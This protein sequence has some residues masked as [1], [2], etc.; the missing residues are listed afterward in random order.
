M[1]E[2]Q[3]VGGP[4]SRIDRNL[5][6]IIAVVVVALALAILK[7]WGEIAAPIAVASPPPTPTPSPAPTPVPARDVYDLASYGILEPPAIWE[8]WS[9]GTLASFS[10][11]LRIDLAPAPALPA[12]PTPSGAIESDDPT[13]PSATPASRPS[14]STF[15]GVPSQWP[16]VRIPTGSHLELIAINRPLDRTIE[17]V[18]LTQ[19][20]DAGTTVT[21]PTVEAR[22]PWPSHVTVVGLGQ[23]GSDGMR[24]W[25]AGRYEMTLRIGPEGVERTLE[26]VVD[27]LPDEL[28]PSAAPSVAPGG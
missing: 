24:Q 16:P 3:R 26:I 5:G 10:F 19:E 8:V 4:P 21:L 27:T 1:T 14:P 18:S 25:P 15:V 13:R 23:D 6:R 28:V 7:P 9:A 11:A 20:A 22:S 2:L 17:V 12:G